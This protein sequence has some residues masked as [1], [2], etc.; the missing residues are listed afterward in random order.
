MLDKSK[1]DLD[2]F[3]KNYFTTELN[4][5]KAE[6]ESEYWKKQTEYLKDKDAAKEEITMKIKAEMRVAQ[7]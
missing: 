5:K 7:R 6:A 1:N 3:K 2:H 4:F